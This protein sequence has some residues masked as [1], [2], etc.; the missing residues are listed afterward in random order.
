[1]CE[2]KVFL[3]GKEV[4]KD[5]VYAK[6]ENGKVLVRDVIGESREFKN[7]KIVEIDVNKTRLVLAQA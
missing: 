3:N 2:F 5:V 4:F 7:C 6:A 1:M